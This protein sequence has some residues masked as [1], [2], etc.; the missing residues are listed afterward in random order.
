MARGD[1]YRVQRL[2]G[3]G[4]NP[5]AFCIP[6]WSI[7]LAALVA[8]VVKATSAMAMVTHTC[9]GFLVRVGIFRAGALVG[10]SG[11]D[12]RLALRVTLRALQ[13]LEVVQAEKAWPCKQHP[14]R[15]P[16]RDLIGTGGCRRTPC[17]DSRGG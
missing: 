5:A 11:G 6:T 14:F 17:W 7:P 9:L 8:P 10:V 2:A 4:I 12:S 1:V 15:V 13:L 16:H 3:L